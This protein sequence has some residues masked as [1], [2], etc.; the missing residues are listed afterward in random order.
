MKIFNDNI[1]LEAIDDCII[2]NGKQ[3]FCDRVLM[4]DKLKEV[5]KDISWLNPPM[6]FHNPT[7][8]PS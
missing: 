6:P 3:F 2:I 4:V 1:C 7:M 8:P 5:T